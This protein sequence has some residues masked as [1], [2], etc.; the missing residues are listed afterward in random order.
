MLF[1]QLVKNEIYQSKLVTYKEKISFTDIRNILWIILY[2]QNKNFI[3]KSKLMVSGQ[4]SKNQLLD[5]RFIPLRTRFFYD[6]VM[7]NF[8]NHKFACQQ[9]II[10]HMAISCRGAGMSKI[11]VGT[12]LC[13][14]QS[15]L[16]IDSL[17]FIVC[18]V[19]YWIMV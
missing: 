17:R 15:T 7:C 1:W 8:S 5:P 4:M 12:N 11:L 9:L 13:G 2:V 16:N 10:Q 18:A 19:R 3:T 14:G 6:C